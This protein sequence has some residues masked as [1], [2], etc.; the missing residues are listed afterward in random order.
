MG[1]ADAYARRNRCKAPE[2]AASSPQ[3]R[4][5]ATR[6]IAQQGSF[7]GIEDAKQFFG[8]FVDLL[9]PGDFQV[10]TAF[11][12]AQHAASSGT[13]RHTV[14]KTGKAFAI[15]WALICTVKDGHITP[16]TSMRIAKRWFMQCAEGGVGCFETRAAARRKIA[17][18]GGVSLR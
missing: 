4:T 9:E 17:I 5:P 10:T 1:G 6:P 15:D 16:I 7:I 13:L 11:G 3:A 14:R 12:D 2:T 18:R 8:G